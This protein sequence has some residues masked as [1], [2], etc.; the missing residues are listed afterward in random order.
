MA[1]DNTITISSDALSQALERIFAG[2]G[3]SAEHAGIVAASLVDADL[4]GIHSHGAMR[5]AQYLPQIAA[6]AINPTP[7]IRVVRENHGTALLDGDAGMGQ[8]TA[9]LAM[10]KALELAAQSGVGAVGVRHSSHFGAAGYYAEMALAHDMIGFATTN[11]E[12]SL[13]A[14]GG[15]QRVVGNNPLA[16]ALPGGDGPPILLDMA[17]SVVAG[18]K[19]MLAANAG[20]S[21]PL[22][23]ALDGDGNPTTDPR[24]ALGGGMFMPVGGPKGYG[25][26]IVLDMLCGLLTGADYACHLGKQNDPTRCENAGHFFMAIRIDDFVPIAEFRERTAQMIEELRAS[27]RAAGAERIFLP[28]EIEWER[29]QERLASGIPLPAET[30]QKIAAAG[31]RVGVA[32]T[33]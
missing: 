12:P 14:L 17:T 27:K 11:C 4:R 13:P 23:W 19:I 3:L 32:I 9:S 20:Q 2:A 22:G 1:P 16:W 10:Q 8:V 24:A 25:L 5:V 30:V 26:A 6:R 29:K 15:A 28:G 7:A 31:E 18:G 21:I 33:F